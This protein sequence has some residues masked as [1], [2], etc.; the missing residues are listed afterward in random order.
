VPL[1]QARGSIELN[2]RLRY[3]RS[4]GPR[5]GIGERFEREQDRRCS[6]ARHAALARK[7]SQE[8]RL[9]S[10]RLAGLFFGFLF[11]RKSHP[12]ANYRNHR[13]PD[14]NHSRHAH[15]PCISG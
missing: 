6:I 12:T 13:E 9:H 3:V 10:L 5:R 7:I 4:L 14:A 11:F 8:P 15:V 2:L 1:A